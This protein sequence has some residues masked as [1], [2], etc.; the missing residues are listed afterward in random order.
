[1]REENSSNQMQVTNLSVR[2]RCA[3]HHLFMIEA[4]EV[5]ACTQGVLS[6]IMLRSYIQ[7]ML[8]IQDFT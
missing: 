5:L 6:P 8:D 3:F 1:M 4:L 7:Q 2:C